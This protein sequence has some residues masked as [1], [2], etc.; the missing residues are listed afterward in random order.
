MTRKILTHRTAIA[1]VSYSSNEP[2]YASEI[3]NF[4]GNAK[5]RRTARRAFAKLIKY[6]KV[7][8]LLNNRQS[9]NY[10]WVNHGTWVRT[11]I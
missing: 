3:P 4:T 1:H 2:I 10:Y 7:D 6:N 8:D 11:Y 9:I 5:Q